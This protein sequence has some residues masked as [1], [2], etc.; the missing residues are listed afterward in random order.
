M[1]W[2]NVDRIDNWLVAKLK[3]IVNFK[4]FYG[5]SVKN[6]APMAITQADCS[7]VKKSI[8]MFIVYIYR[9]HFNTQKLQ[10]LP[11]AEPSQPH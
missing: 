8:R 6:H 7:H 5:L 4:I 2:R 11:Q 1:F 9:E 3:I 10:F